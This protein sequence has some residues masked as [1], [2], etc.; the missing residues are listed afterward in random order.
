MR[1]DQRWIGFSEADVNNLR[2][3]GY[4]PTKRHLS[5]RVDDNAFHPD[6]F[7]M[8]PFCFLCLKRK[9]EKDQRWIG[10]S[11]ADVNNL[12]RRGYQATKR[13]LSQRVEDNAF[14]HDGVPP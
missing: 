13:H 3:R 2:R 7:A 14:H 5:Q 4:Q 6:N 11:E 10:F 8:P 9:C 1:E 12:R